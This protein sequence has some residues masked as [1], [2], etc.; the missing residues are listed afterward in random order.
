[1]L[2]QVHDELV[3]DIPEKVVE[4]KKPVNLADKTRMKV[5]VR[6]PKAGSK[7][8]WVKRKNIDKWE[9]WSSM[10][11]SNPETVTILRTEE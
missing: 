8:F 1:M 2:I 6:N 9:F 10:A 3:F 7:K 5:K 4:E 11:I